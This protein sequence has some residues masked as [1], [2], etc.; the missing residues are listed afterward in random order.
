MGHMD[1]R[2]SQ[3]MHD[4]TKCHLGA[5]MNAI[6]ALTQPLSMFRHHRSLEWSV[7]LGSPAT[8]QMAA[9]SSRVVAR[10]VAHTV[11][12]ASLAGAV[13]DFQKDKQ[14]RKLNAVKDTIEIKTL[15]GGHLTMVTNHDLVVGDV[16]ILDAGDK[17]VADM[18]MFESHGLV[19]D[20]ASLTGESEPIKKH[21][22]SD[23]WLR[24]G[25]QVM[26]GLAHLPHMKGGKVV[27]YTAAFFL[28]QY[29][30]VRPSISIKLILI[31][32]L[33]CPSRSLKAVDGPS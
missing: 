17:I 24:S 14:F 18:L 26:R 25:T 31:P 32:Y 22:D 23:P 28:I 33:M 2:L 7:W 10:L 3:T 6:G 21:L 9:A 5:H 11:S 15:R 30:R 19:V 8:T 13:N 1:D 20:E 16:V 12:C 29:G 27:A 4:F